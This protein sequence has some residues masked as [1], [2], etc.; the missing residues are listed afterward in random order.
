MKRKLAKGALAFA[1]ALA[2]TL[3]ASASTVLMDGAFTGTIDVTASSVSPDVTAGG[4]V[5]MTVGNPAPSLNGMATYSA[6]TNAPATVIFI[7]HSLSYD[8]SILGTIS[9]INGSYDRETGDTGGSQT[10]SKIFRLVIEQ[11]GF[12]YVSDVAICSHCDPGG[13]WYNLAA[14]DLVASDFTEIGGSQNLIFTGDPILFGVEFLIS[15]N[16][17]SMTPSITA[18]YGYIDNIDITVNQ[19]PL[20]AALPLFATGLGVMGLF[21]WRKKN[22]AAAL[23]A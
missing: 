7:D 10:I 6:S 23:A 13:T 11:D 22:K 1:F 9:S 12:D 16:D 14:S 20:P 8:P 15:I 21:G 4:A 2:S 18:S 19:T 5:S 3:A 17:P